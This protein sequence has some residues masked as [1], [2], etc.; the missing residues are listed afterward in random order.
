L[1]LILG[2][3][4]ASPAALAHAPALATTTADVTLYAR[5]S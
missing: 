4:L 5:S 3:L 2:A 1:A